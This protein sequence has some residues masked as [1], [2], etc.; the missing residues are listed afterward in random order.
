MEGKIALVCGPIDIFNSC[1]NKSVSS[2]T[3]GILD[4]GAGCYITRVRSDF[5]FIEQ[6]PSVKIRGAGGNVEGGKPV[7]FKGRLRS[8]ALDLKE[9]VFFPALPVER[10]VSS[11]VLEDNGWILILAGLKSMALHRVR[12]LEIPIERDPETNLP[13]IEVFGRQAVFVSKTERESGVYT[14]ESE[15]DLNFVPEREQNLVCPEVNENIVQNSSSSSDAVRGQESSIFLSSLALHRR[16]CHLSSPETKGFK[17]PECLTAKARRGSHEKVRRPIYTAGVP[18]RDLATDFWGPVTPSIRRFTGVQV[19][20]CDAVSKVWVF[21]IRCKSSC[22]ENLEKLVRGLRATYGKRLGEKVVHSIRSD[23][24][25]VLRSGK[26]DA[27]ILGLQLEERHSVPF[28]PQQN[29]VCERW[30]ATLG[31][32][33]RAALQSVDVSLWCYA[34]EAIAHAYAKIRRNY[35]RAPRWNG[36]APDEVLRIWAR[37]DLVAIDE[38]IEKAR[39][40]TPAY[41]KHLRRFGCLAFVK[42]P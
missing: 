28:T 38:E 4:S 13:W 16:Y 19:F 5:V 41:E 40:T 1:S 21:P 14:Q 29:G 2:S 27:A 36:L 3:G 17:C 7:G 12:G 10:L 22:V 20:V 8:N 32:G 23:N 34:A 30:M 11:I 9:G 6:R 25:P 37:R 31:G 26:M 15:Q 24:E 39:R 18:L 42:I 35:P 33:L